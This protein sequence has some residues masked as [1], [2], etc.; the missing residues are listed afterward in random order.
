MPAADALATPEHVLALA[1]R[2]SDIASA[3]VRAIQAITQ[4][5]R[6]LALNATIEAGRAGEAGAG[7]G[8]VAR[9][10]KS[11]ATEV[12]R[13]AGEMDGELGEAFQAL[14]RVG[15]RMATEVRDQRLVDLALNAIEIMDRNL[16]ERTCDVRWWA[17]D[18][19]LV[20]AAAQPSPERVA[21]AER[22]LGVILSAYTVYLDLWLC[23]ISGRVIAHGRPDRHPGVRGL[24]VQHEPWFAAA[25]A[26]RDGQ[27]FA[28]ADVAP[29]AAL[30]GAP[31][32]TYATAVR[33]GGEGHGEPIGALA[34]HFDWEP[35]AAS[36][37]TGIR[38][39]AAEAGRTRA[40][41]LDGAGRVLAASDGS[42]AFSEQVPLPGRL[43]PSGS[44]TLRDGRTLAWH[45]TPGFE[46]YR[47]LGWYGAII[48]SA[49]A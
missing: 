41:L 48:Q 42:G 20:D 18:A 9:E 12:A 5:T 4:Q 26:T 44:T 23:D 10:V 32:A 14:R 16:Y 17:T 35:Q 27:G 38:L 1:A 45:R 8:V 43:P 39:T 49:A 25:L 7:F 13:L 34:V 36:V 30:G 47:G 3:K 28:V 11:V 19:A 33:A 29:C 2:A 46:T 37:V 6:I 24:A 21:H 40:L 22:R 31:V 15:E